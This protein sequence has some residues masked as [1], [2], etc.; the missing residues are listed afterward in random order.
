MWATSYV[1]CHNCKNERYGWMNNF[2]SEHQDKAE[3]ISHIIPVCKRCKLERPNTGFSSFL[4][5]ILKIEH[6]I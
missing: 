6:T 5:I 2:H 3:V 4:K 1:L